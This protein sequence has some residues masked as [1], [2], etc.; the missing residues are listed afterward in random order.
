MMHRRILAAAAI[1]AVAGLAQTAQQ[2]LTLDSGQ[3]LNFS[4]GS[5]LHTVHGSIPLAG[6]VILFDLETG[7]A[8][9]EVQVEARAA[10]TGNDKRDKKM[11]SKVLE[12]ESFPEIVFSAE[13]IEG[14]LID[15]QSSR[16]TLKGQIR[17]HGSEHPA[18]IE[19][20]VTQAGTHITA[21]GAL[22]IPYVAWGLDDPSVFVLR[23]DKIVEVDLK[24]RGTLAP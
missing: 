14:E 1:L 11:H 18:Q 10:E 24:V 5:T 17:L 15:G 22:S 23:V 8:S 2:T 19:A 21:N 13:S 7:K 16:V 12:S 4:L 9:G 6:G 3:V 20:E